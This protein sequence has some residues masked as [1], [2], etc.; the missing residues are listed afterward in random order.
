M[1]LILPVREIQ[2]KFMPELTKKLNINNQFDYNL[3]YCDSPPVIYQW[4]G[5]EYT[6]FT[7][8]TNAAFPNESHSIFSDPE[9]LDL[10]AT[11]FDI[12]VSSFLIFNFGFWICSRKKFFSPR[13]TKVKK[14]ALFQVCG[15]K[16]VETNYNADILSML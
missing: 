14:M 12:I 1:R 3:F 2:L 8:Y 13:Y 16:Y 6:E 5:G 4:K 15:T 9:F 11:N 7:G 10:V